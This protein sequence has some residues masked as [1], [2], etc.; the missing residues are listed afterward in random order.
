MPGH[1]ITY[2]PLAAIGLRLGLPSAERF[3]LENL[4]YVEEDHGADVAQD[5][6]AVIR[7]S[8]ETAARRLCETLCPGADFSVS[9]GHMTSA[10]F[11]F[12][13]ITG[14]V[15]LVRGPSFNSDPAVALAQAAINLNRHLARAAE[16]NASPTP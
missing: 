1:G 12:E 4:A 11:R 9:V 16:R 7:D 6:L 2:D 10:T 8:C 13:G 14:E 15:N 3:I 5:L